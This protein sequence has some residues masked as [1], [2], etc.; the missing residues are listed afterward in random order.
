MSSKLGATNN[1]E[2][3]R[4]E[5]GAGSAVVHRDRRGRGD[6]LASTPKTK[7]EDGFGLDVVANVHLNARFFEGSLREAERRPE[8]GWA[9]SPI[10]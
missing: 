8:C 10:A 2:I 3:V 7:M 1:A 5:N 4:A 9:T 6:G